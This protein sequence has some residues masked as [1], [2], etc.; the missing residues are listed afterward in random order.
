MAKKALDTGTFLDGSGS[1]L[2]SL[3]VNT[4]ALGTNGYYGPV[5]ETAS[6][7]TLCYDEQGRLIN[8]FCN[9]R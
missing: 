8:A 5:V 9:G 6:G 7:T 1:T 3:D 2:N 4:L